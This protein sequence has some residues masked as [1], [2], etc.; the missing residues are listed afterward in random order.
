MANDPFQDLLARVRSV[1]DLHALL[2]SGQ[3]DLDVLLFDAPSRGRGDP[4]G[5]GHTGLG[6]YADPFANYIFGTRD[7]EIISGTGQR[8]IIMAGGGVDV[9]SAKNGDDIVYGEEGNDIVNGADGNDRLSG[10]PGRDMLSAGY[11]GWLNVLNGGRDADHL[12]GSR[13]ANVIDVFQFTQDIDAP[14]SIDS[15]P[16]DRIYA[17]RVGEDFLHFVFDA[18][19]FKPGYQGFEIVAEEDAGSAGTIWFDQLDAGAADPDDIW[20]N[21]DEGWIDLILHGHTDNDGAIDF[22]IAMTIIVDMDAVDISADDAV[23]QA[24]SADDFMF[25]Q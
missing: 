17:F 19:A 4:G 3:V 7:S 8:D 9:V 21:D 11:D 24:L 10:G 12:Y 6:G 16:I 23:Y 5:A 15:S 13:Y 22:S 20:I 14:P 2:R 25:G 18:N 1:E